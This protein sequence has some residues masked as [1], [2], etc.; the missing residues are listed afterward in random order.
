MES[1]HGQLTQ[2]RLQFGY[3]IRWWWVASRR[4]LVLAVERRKKNK[5]QKWKN[6]VLVPYSLIS[7]QASELYIP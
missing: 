2:R 5:S 6:I 4:R 1:S 3:L 7:Q